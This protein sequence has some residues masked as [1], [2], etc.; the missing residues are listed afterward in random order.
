MSRSSGPQPIHSTINGNVG[1][2]IQ[3]QNM[4]TGT[5]IFDEDTLAKLGVAIAAQTNVYADRQRTRAAVNKTLA[6]LKSRGVMYARMDLESWPAAFRSLKDVRDALA[7]LSVELRNGP[8]SVRSLVDLLL[9]AVRDYIICWEASYEKSQ[10]VSFSEFWPEQ[11]A[12]G[13][14][15][16][17]IRVIGLAAIEPLETYASSK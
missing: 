3:V 17:S 11:K 7:D 9:A 16:H 1:K 4:Y 10:R 5:E 8:E 13:I 14:A 6:L 12:A 15:L 2:L